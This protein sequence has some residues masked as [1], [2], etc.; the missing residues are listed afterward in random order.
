[1]TNTIL[2]TK[3]PMCVDVPCKNI[4]IKL[5]RKTYQDNSEN[6]ITYHTLE[7]Q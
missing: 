1:M 7:T 2:G 3:W 4:Q 6:V 5:L